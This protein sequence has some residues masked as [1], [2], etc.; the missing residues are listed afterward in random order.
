VH[1]AN[2]TEFGQYLYK[3]ARCARES[4]GFQVRRGRCRART[5]GPVAPGPEFDVDERREDGHFDQRDD[6][7]GE[8]FAG[9]GVPPTSGSGTTPP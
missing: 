3:T 2:Y 1:P 5:G 4:T 9:G 7:A 6:D 8:R